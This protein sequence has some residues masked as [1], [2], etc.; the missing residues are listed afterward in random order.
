VSLNFVSSTNKI[1]NINNHFH[2]L[3]SFL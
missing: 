2:G 1:D 3:D